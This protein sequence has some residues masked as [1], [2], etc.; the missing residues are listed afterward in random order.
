MYLGNDGQA[1]L[2]SEPRRSHSDAYYI[3]NRQECYAKTDSTAFGKHDF[4]T[5]SWVSEGAD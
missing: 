1:R 5:G 4:D 2:I 3:S